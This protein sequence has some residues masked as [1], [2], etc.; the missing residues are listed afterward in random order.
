MKR[1]QI[2]AILVISVTLILFVLSFSIAIKHRNDAANVLGHRY[3]RTKLRV[4]MDLYGK[5]SSRS[6]T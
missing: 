5:A 2:I 1:N 4:V 6:K 3:G